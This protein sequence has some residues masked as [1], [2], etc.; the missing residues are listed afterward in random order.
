LT[1]PLIDDERPGVVVVHTEQDIE[2]VL[3]SVAR[4]REIMLN[5]GPNKLI[6]RVPVSVAE[7]AVWGLMPPGFAPMPPSGSA[8]GSSF[9]PAAVSR[10]GQ[11]GT[12]PVR[13]AGNAGAL[14]FRER[15]VTLA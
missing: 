3:D 11:Q 10:A 1:V 2:P 15:H 4:D 7:R 6:G 13:I 8:T 9:R 12:N 14:R 5:N